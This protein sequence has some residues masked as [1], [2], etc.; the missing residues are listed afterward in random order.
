MKNVD[1][2]PEEVRELA[3]NIKNAVDR[4]TNT[5]YIIE[6]TKHDL[7]KVNRIKQDARYAELVH[8]LI[9]ISMVSISSYI[10]RA[11]ATKLLKEAEQV[12]DT[13]N[14]THDA[15]IDAETAI[16]KVSEEYKNVEKIL[17]EVRTEKY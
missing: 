13:L 15:Q 6:A 2:T 14:K 7:A 4:L 8:K 12:N 11:N 3:A 1:K 10:F 16:E 9:L 17:G 5:D